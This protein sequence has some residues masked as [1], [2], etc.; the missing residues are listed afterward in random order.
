[1]GRKNSPKRV[2]SCNPH[3]PCWAIGSVVIGGTPHLVDFGEATLLLQYQITCRKVI[4]KSHP[5]YKPGHEQWHFLHSSFVEGEMRL[6]PGRQ[7]TL[8][9]SKPPKAQE[10]VFHNPLS[11][12]DSY[13]TCIFLPLHRFNLESCAFGR[14]N[15]SIFGKI[16]V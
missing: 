12:V 10:M 8:A 11:K 6:V 1:M 9:V 5:L 15:Q 2:L 3:C 4:E 14:L 16:G 13:A 7:R